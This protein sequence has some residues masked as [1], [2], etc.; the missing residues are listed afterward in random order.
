MLKVYPW[1]RFTFPPVN[2]TFLNVPVGDREII[3]GA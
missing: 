2:K 1:E 3:V